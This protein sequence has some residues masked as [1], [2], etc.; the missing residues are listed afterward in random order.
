MLSSLA[1]GPL[2]D[3]LPEV[4]GVAGGCGGR[5]V[6]AASKVRDADRGVEEEWN[7]K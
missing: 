4:F 1:S 7:G 5:G 6:A 3:L 2:V